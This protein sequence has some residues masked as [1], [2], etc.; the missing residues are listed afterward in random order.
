[1]AKKTH[2]KMKEH[3]MAQKIYNKLEVDDFE[4]IG[5]KGVDTI[6]I[7]QILNRL[8]EKNKTEK[9]FKTKQGVITRCR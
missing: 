6:Y 9:V 2:A 3:S 7:K 1:M 5:F 4:F 8:N